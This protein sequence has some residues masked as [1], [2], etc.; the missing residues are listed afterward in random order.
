[1]QVGS[2]SNMDLSRTTPL[3]PNAFPG[4]QDPATR[5]DSG[6]GSWEKAKYGASIGHINHDYYATEFGW[7]AG[8]GDMIRIIEKDVDLC[9][10]FSLV[11]ALY[12]G[13]SEGVD[14]DAV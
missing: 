14:E 7:L 6:A 4:S 13:D 11:R 8:S 3:S 2:D 9:W 5:N 12:K 10:P 1:M